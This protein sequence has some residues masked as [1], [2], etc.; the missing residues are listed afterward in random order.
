MIMFIDSDPNPRDDEPV[1]WSGVVRQT[2]GTASLLS[3]AE[4]SLSIGDEGE[5]QAPADAPAGA[6]VTIEIAIAEF[7]EMKFQP[8][9]ER[10]LRHQQALKA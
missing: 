1:V 8:A 4:P 2:R 9:L 10:A 3:P 5:P 6:L 7:L